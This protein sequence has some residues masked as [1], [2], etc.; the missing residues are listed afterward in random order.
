[1]KCWSLQQNAGDLAT[2]SPFVGCSQIIGKNSRFWFKNT[3]NFITGQKISKILRVVYISRHSFIYQK[4]VLTLQLSFKVK[5]SQAS[6]LICMYLIIVSY[7]MHLCLIL[8]ARHCWG[9]LLLSISTAV[10][11]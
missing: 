11:H 10:E 3:Y 2:M 9:Q 1:M 8:Q 4:I 7:V 5:Q 6:I